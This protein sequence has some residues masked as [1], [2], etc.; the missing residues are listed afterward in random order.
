M[1]IN[2][3]PCLIINDAY[4]VTGA[5]EP[6]VLLRIIDLAAENALGGTINLSQPDHH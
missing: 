6:E 1:N 4:A 3:V 2:G 5:Q